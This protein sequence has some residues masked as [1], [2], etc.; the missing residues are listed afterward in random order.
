MISL[1]EKNWIDRAS[2]NLPDKEVNEFTFHLNPKKKGMFKGKS[3]KSIEKSKKHDTG[4]KKKEDVFAINAKEGKFGHHH[5]EETEVNELSDKKLGDYVTKARDNPKKRRILGRDRPR[6]K[7][8]ATATSKLKARGYG[9][10]RGY[11][12]KEEEELDEVNLLG[13]KLNTAKP[14]GER[15]RVHGKDGLKR[16]KYRYSKW[17]E[18]TIDE[19]KWAKRGQKIKKVLEKPWTA[20]NK[21]AGIKEE[22]IDETKLMG[23]ETGVVGAPNFGEA[24]LPA[25]TGGPTGKK[26]IAGEF[27]RPAKKT[28]PGF[29]NATPGTVKAYLASKG[30]SE[31][32]INSLIDSYLEENPE[33]EEDQA[34]DDV[35]EYLMSE[36]F[37][38]VGED[39]S[40]LL[41]EI[42]DSAFSDN[43]DSFSDSFADAVQVVI[44]D[45][46]ADK[47]LELQGSLLGVEEF[48]PDQEDEVEETEDGEVATGDSEDTETE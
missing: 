47:K 32:M 10:T 40:V 39:A 8:I 26:P 19:G 17:D 48:V 16:K 6:D 9:I 44:N 12:H 38:D 18:E 35:F 22:D 27:C 36:E 28:D 23:P 15:V 13:K 46:V 3:L 11:I 41:T 45:M 31:D 4:T 33:I 20:I 7:G 25:P 24:E 1:T 2:A 43:I 42:V 37:E 30:V 29:G 34:I 14:S 21:L 5:K